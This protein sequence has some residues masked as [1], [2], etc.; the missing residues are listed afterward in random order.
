MFIFLLIVFWVYY[1]FFFYYGG[2]VQGVVF[3][4]LFNN[5]KYF[6]NC[7]LDVFDFGEEFQIV[8]IVIDGES[9]G[10]YYKKGEMVL[11]DCFNSIE[12]WDG[13]DLI[14]YG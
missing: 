1:F 13:I 4:G 11:V 6:V 5:G 8:Y 9:Y 3:E 14:N 12:K 7:L 10:Y 2:V